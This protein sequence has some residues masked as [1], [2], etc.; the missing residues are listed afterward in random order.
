M[1]Q[2][3]IYL[4]Y[5][6]GTSILAVFV[7]KKKSIFTYLFILLIVSAWSTYTLV[8]S[9]EIVG[10]R[11][12][13]VTWFKKIYPLYASN[14]NMILE[15]DNE[16]GWVLFN[17][18]LSKLFNSE[19]IA[20][21]IYMFFPMLVSVIFMYKQ[22]FPFYKIHFLFSLTFIPYYCTYL[23]R[24]MFAYSFG[25][26][27]IY[28]YINNKK[29]ISVFFVIM[30]FLFHKSA[31]IILLAFIIFSYVNSKRKIL[32]FALGCILILPVLPTLISLVF[33]IFNI[34]KW[35][36]GNNII[37]TAA[38]LKSI[39]YL[40]IFILG[41]KNYN[42]LKRNKYLNIYLIMTFLS[43]FFWITTLFGTWYYRLNIY[44]LIGVILFVLISFKNIKSKDDRII[45]VLSITL[46]FLITLREIYLMSLY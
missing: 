46:I 33:Q 3:L 38:V 42:I 44:F 39:P 26:I 31:V 4:L 36:V 8:W 10:D 28:T 1:N 32:I 7:T 45:L 13:Y 37:I 15:Q 43:G 12:N 9:Y 20:L 2:I 19:K 30:A 41:I 35:K 16:I 27:A 34:N 22:K 40:L 14:F 17:T 18:I 24:Q 25:L 11:M 21:Y 23:C 29:I 6:M 5:I